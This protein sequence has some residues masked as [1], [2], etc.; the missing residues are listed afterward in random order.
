MNGRSSV[1]SASVVLGVLAVLGATAACGA[2]SS[3]H[4]IA[5]PSPSIGAVVDGTLPT[6]IATMPL[7]E[8]NGTRT[9]LAAFYGKSVMIADFMTLC[10]DICPMI[11]ANTASLARSLS[12]DRE[13][14]RTALLEITIDPHRDTPARMHAYQR[15]YGAHAGNWYLLRASA[16]DTRKLWHYFGVYAKHVKEG[17]PA[18]RDWLTGKPLTYDIAHSDDVIFLNAQGQERFVIDGNPDPQD[19]PLPLTLRKDLSA[20]GRELLAHPDAAQDWTTGQALRV[21]SW[22][23]N[24]PLIQATQ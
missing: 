20:Q 14:A 22:L 9:D 10:T 18:D 24:R 2:S 1:R 6:N 19:H 21:F 12:H 5:A 15:L 8:A 3:P 7:T 23:L 17:T 11:S 4:K 16:T 13:T